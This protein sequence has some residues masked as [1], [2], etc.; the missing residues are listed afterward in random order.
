MKKYMFILLILLTVCF[1]MVSCSNNDENENGN[2]L[3]KTEKDAQQK[4]NDKELEESN[5][6]T[7]NNEKNDD[8]KDKDVATPNEEEQHIEGTVFV[9]EDENM[10]RVEAE[11]N[12]VE[13]TPTKVSLRRAY[14]ITDVLGGNSEKEEVESDGT[15]TIDYELGDDFFE[16]YHGLYAEVKIEV[17]PS[18]NDL[19]PNTTEAYGSDGENFNGPFVYQYEVFD[20]KQKLVA[21]VVIKIGDEDTEYSIETPERESL[22]DDYGETEVWMEAEIVDN[23]HRFFY[24]EG[25]TNILEGTRFLGNYYSDDDA[26]T[27]QIGNNT[28][29]NIEPDG[30]FFLPVRYES[31]TDNG[32]IKINSAA[33]YK[34]ENKEQILEM[35]GE[36]FEK[37]TGDIVKNEDSHQE[38]ELILK[39]EGLDV[40]APEN[41][42]ITESDGELKIQVPDDVLFD[43]DKSDLKDE[44]KDTLDEVMDILADLDDG[45][46]VQINGHTDNQGDAD[47]NLELS[48][49]RAD[50]VKNY[51]K[52]NGDV[53]HLDLDTKGYGETDP[54]ASNENEEGQERNRRVEIVFDKNE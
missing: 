48:E 46:N 53:D 20:P 17:E 26:N 25:K 54:V 40:D 14:G 47:Y 18:D 50:S 22:P 6:T 43:F 13:G 33:S 4:D 34:H 19:H 9:K 16:N 1:V 39:T 49:Q 24:V 15:V 52:N 7:K 31:I 12:L 2:N 37:L 42:H 51:L 28:A 44:A 5:N 11:T 3:N 45:L 27:P 38:I 30:S 29:V 21:P 36:N 8:D 35:Y 10:I 41:S 23:D 32:Y